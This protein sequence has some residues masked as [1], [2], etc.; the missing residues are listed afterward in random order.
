MS[1]VEASPSAAL[2]ETGLA[3]L[4]EPLVA[5]APTQSGDTRLA[6]RDER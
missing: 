6:T 4:V 2:D 5:R 3:A 1:S